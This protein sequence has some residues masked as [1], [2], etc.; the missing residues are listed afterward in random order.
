MA[1]ILDMWHHIEGRYGRLSPDEKD[2]VDSAIHPH[3][4]KFRGFDG[5][6]EVQF[7]IARCLVGDMGRWTG[8]KDRDLNSH[9]PSIDRHRRM[10]NM[11]RP[12]RTSLSEDPLSQQELVELLKA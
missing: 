1:D 12:R 3:E 9:S 4:A 2:K 8:F 5:N 6:N 10:L 7:G 11:F